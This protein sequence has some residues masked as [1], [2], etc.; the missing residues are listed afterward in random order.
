MFGLVSAVQALAFDDPGTKSL[1]SIEE[2][3]PFADV[4]RNFYTYTYSTDNEKQQ[5]WVFLV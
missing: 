3:K 1:S 2:Q 5:G 4:A